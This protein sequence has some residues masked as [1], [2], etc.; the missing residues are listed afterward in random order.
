MDALT[1][2]RFGPRFFKLLQDMARG[3]KAT[4][5]LSKLI[6]PKLAIGGP[7]N[8][9]MDFS[10]IANDFKSTTAERSVRDTVDINL[11]S[12]GQRVTIQAEREQARAFV[13]ILRQFEKG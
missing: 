6:I 2:S 8:G 1:T 10:A 9:S 3:G 4:T 11:T 7:V 12:G 13:G 5:F